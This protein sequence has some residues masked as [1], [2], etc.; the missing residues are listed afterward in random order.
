MVTL[1]AL[2]TL[3]LKGK[4]AS[5]LKQTPVKVE[6]HCFL[7]SGVSSSGGCS[8]RAFHCSSSSWKQLNTTWKYQY[9]F[10][11]KFTDS[12]LNNPVR[13]VQTLQV[14]ILAFSKVPLTYWST[15]LEISARF[16]PALNFMP[17]TRG[18]CLSHQLSALSPASRVQCMR[19]CCPAPIPTT[20]QRRT[21][22]SIYIDF[23]SFN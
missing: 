4:K 13:V 6:I 21:F 7:S 3:S 9:T 19:D 23:G 11:N 20:W 18:W 22:L 16:T 10:K 1:L 8:N 17:R 14:C 2:S 15:A 12:R 5:E